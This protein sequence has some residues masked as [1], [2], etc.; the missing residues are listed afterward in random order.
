MR[1]LIDALCDLEIHWR[2]AWCFVVGH[3]WR[4]YGWQ[5]LPHGRFK[6]GDLIWR[7]RDCDKEKTHA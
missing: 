4:F 7:C 3:R 2:R 5:V 6:P 1:D